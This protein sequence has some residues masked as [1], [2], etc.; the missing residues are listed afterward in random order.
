MISGFEPG[1]ARVNGVDIAY[2]A[3]G[4][5]A[6]L[7]LLHGFP[8]NSALWARVAPLLARERRV[9]VADLR[10]HGASSKPAGTPAYSFREMG[11]DMLALMRHLGHETFDLAGHDRGG[12][13]AHRMAL[14]APGRIAR[15]ALMDI[16]PTHL[17]LT[18][19]THE[20]A[21]AYY[22]W[23]FLSQPAPLPE[24]MIGA[25][26]D[27]FFESC[28]VG[29][30]AAKL[31]DFA[32]DQ[33]AAYRSAWRDPENIRGM[34]S[35]YRAAIECDL[36]LDAADLG[37]VLAMPCLIMWGADGAM[38]RAYDVPGCWADRFADITP[39]PIPGGHFF[40]DTAP[41]PT[42]QALSGFLNG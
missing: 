29:W 11:G 28:L 27:F 16:I 41:N 38:G 21:R 31:G 12:R 37:R 39:C 32:P 22:H 5:G 24:R 20:V 30:G 19:L 40:V 8:Q 10:G 13:V 9:V 3:G 7:L 35:D 36:A 2:A 25:D 17:L 15:I 26:A 42:A 33:L 14:D 6:P 34:C 1:R 23:F 18:G 4:A